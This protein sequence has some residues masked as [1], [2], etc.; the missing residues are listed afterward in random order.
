MDKKASLDIIR[1]DNDFFK[2]MID[3]IPP[4]FYFDKDQ[5]NEGLTSVNANGM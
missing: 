2:S 4:K 1:K 3:L 5:L